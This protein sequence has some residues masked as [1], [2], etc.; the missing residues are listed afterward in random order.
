ML[1]VTGLFRDQLMSPMKRAA[2]PIRVAGTGQP[3]RRYPPMHNQKIAMGIAVG[4]AIGA[5]MGAAMDN[6]GM[7]VGIGL[8]LGI[9][10][11]SAWKAWDKRE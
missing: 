3:R 8:A 9:A 10:L 2:S 4:I 1:P 6:I 11:G 7:G 5:G